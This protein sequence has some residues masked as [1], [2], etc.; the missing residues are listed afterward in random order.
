LNKTVTG[1]VQL[2]RH[3]DHLLQPPMKLYNALF[4]KQQTTL[5]TFH[6]S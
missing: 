6:L 3:A 4:R 2:L 5:G 1:F